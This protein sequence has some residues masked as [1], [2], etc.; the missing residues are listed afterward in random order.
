M[1]RRFH[2]I[3]AVA[4]SGAKRQKQ[5][6]RIEETA[7]RIS[8]ATPLGVTASQLSIWLADEARR[9]G[10][11]ADISLGASALP[12]GPLSSQDEIN[13][14]SRM[15]RESGRFFEGLAKA[16]EPRPV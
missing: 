9:Q 11:P 14:M 15:A 12:L 8:A 10:V 1:E 4:V 7:R 6:F 13:R 2:G 5:I 3:V 16:M